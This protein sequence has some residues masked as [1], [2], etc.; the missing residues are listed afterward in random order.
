MASRDLPSP[1]P[2]PRAAV[3][4]LEDLMARQRP[5]T[6]RL[7]RLVA[8]LTGRPRDMAEL[9]Q[10]SALPRQSVEAVLAA[11]AGDLVRDREAVAIQPA[12]VPEY[13]ERFGY[14]ELGRTELTDPLAAQLADAAGIPARPAH[15]SADAPPASPDLAHGPATPLA[16]VLPAPWPLRT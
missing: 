3:S 11:I 5:A 6:R 8:L 9:I 10:L 14:A 12:R 16:P 4:G 1:G 13:R 2:A 15:L 7:R